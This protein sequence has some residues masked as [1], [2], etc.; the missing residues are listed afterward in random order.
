MVKR[1]ARRLGRPKPK[2]TSLVL[3]PR[4]S[5]AKPKAKH[6]LGVGK[7]KPTS[8]VLKPRSSGAGPKAKHHKGVKK[9]HRKSAM[10]IMSGAKKSA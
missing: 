2:S 10:D 3:K 8:L 7:P 9:V 1:Q 6:H 4:K 5:G